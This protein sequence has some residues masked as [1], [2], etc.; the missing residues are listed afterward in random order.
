MAGTR[1]SYIL[2]L[3]SYISPATR[4]RARVSV[5]VCVWQSIA[6]GNAARSCFE[7]RRVTASSC[8][9]WTTASAETMRVTEAVASRQRGTAVSEARRARRP[10]FPPYQPPLPC[11]TPHTLTLSHS[12][13]TSFI[14]H[15]ASY[16]LQPLTSRYTLS[17]SRFTLYACA[18]S[19]CVHTHT[20]T[21]HSHSHSTLTH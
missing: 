19:T 3:I 8:P 16:I 1:T 9:C 21:S 18:R 10:T 20:H 5:S 13:P 14:L 2:H 17:R 11:Y 12:H 6:S 7:M 4:P 15:P